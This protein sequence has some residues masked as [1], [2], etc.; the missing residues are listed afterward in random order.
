MVEETLEM[1]RWREGI[2]VGKKSLEMGVERRDETGLGEERKVFVHPGPWRGGGKQRRLHRQTR[3]LGPLGNILGS[4]YTGDLG[5][6]RT[7]RPLIDQEDLRL[8]LD[9][10]NE[11]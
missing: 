5:R 9:E 10:R 2:A 11:R 3:L 8:L 6:Y 4:R 7:L 1:R